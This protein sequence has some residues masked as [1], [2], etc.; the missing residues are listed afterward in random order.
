M[1][2]N[3]SEHSIYCSSMAQYNQALKLHPYV[4]LQYA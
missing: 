1:T 2:D 4:D 3:S